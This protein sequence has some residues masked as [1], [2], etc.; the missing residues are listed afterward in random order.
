M[1]RNNDKP[2]YFW[3]EI[4]LIRRLNFEMVAAVSQQLESFERILKYRNGPKKILISSKDE[5]CLKL[6]QQFSKNFR[7]MITDFNEMVLIL[8]S[9]LNQIDKDDLNVSSLNEWAVSIDQMI[10]FFRI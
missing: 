2:L 6:F 5:K 9:H 3:F 4:G 8:H 1:Q 7:S 10:P